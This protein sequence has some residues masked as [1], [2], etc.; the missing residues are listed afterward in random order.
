M[1]R[2][3]PTVSTVN[4]LS[5]DI[6]DWFHLVEIEAVADPSKW[7]SF[8]SLVELHTRWILD[9]LERHHVRATFFVLGWIADRHPDLVRDIAARGHE[10]GSHSY[11]HRPVFQLSPQEF[12][13]DM[14]RS[15]EAIY[16]A[17]GYEV[18]GF[19]APSFSIT[20]GTEWAFDV[21]AKLG[22][23]YD[24]S[25]FPARRGHGGYPRSEGLAAVRGP[26]GPPLKEL[27]MTVLRLGPLGIPFSGGGYFRLFPFGMIRWGI[28]HINLRGEPVV[29]YLHPRDFAPETP[30]IPMSLARRFKV[31]YGLASTRRK[32]ERLIGSFSFVA[33]DQILGLRA[34]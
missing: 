7:A 24:A 3:E 25:L 4:A 23:R 2:I 8:P 33:C 22:F 29:V 34:G 21:L 17:S 18:I 16:R 15:Q 10:L 9:C 19:R 13:E 14:A 5:F 12:E 30:S 27:P 11:W 6:E 26:E 32:L 20:P 1:E 28:R 31:Y